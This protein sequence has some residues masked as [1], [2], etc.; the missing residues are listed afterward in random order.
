MKIKNIKR[1]LEFCRVT[2]ASGNISIT[3]IVLVITLY[4]I[5]Q[6]SNL[7]LPD[8]ATFLASVIG[9]QV[10]RFALPPSA[11]EDTTDIAAAVAK[12]QTTVS[13]MQLGTQMNRR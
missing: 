12:L 5:T 11:P 2:D 7:S 6:C 3:N 8:L 13:A 9:Y 4:R 10:K 1:A